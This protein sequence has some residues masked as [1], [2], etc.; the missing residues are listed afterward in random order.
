ME[1]F[2]GLARARD[3]P[4]R[5]KVESL[6]H[7]ARDLAGAARPVVGGRGQDQLVLGS[8][9][10]HVEE[11]PLL[12][13]V[14]VAAGQ[15]F[16]HE[17]G[18]QAQGVA[19]PLQRELLLGAA[20]QEDDR[21]LE[22]LGL[23][24]GEDV[25]R[26]VVAFGLGDGRIVAGLAQEVEVRDERGDAVVL[27]HVAVGLHGL[28]ELGDVLD[29][30]L[31]RGA[32]LGGQAPEGPGALEEAVED[33]A[34]AP[35]RH[36]LGGLVEIGQEPLRRLPGRA[37]DPEQVLA[38]GERAQDL[39]QRPRLPARVLIEPQEIDLGH[40]VDLR[41]AE[42]EERD[43]VVGAREHAEERDEEP[44]LL[45]RVEP[46]A[47]AEAMRDALD[48]QGAEEGLGVPVAAHQDGHVARARALLDPLLD[49]GG[50]A[51]GL[52][53]G[54]VEGQVTHG[55]VPR[56]LR[57][58]ALVD[59][60][61]HLQPI[62]VVVADE[63][64]RRVEDELGG[65]MVLGEDHLAGPGVE[66]AEGEQVGR[67]GASPTVDGLIVVTHHRDVGR[68]AGHELQHLELRVVRVLELV[69]Q[70]VAVAGAKTLQDRRAG[71]AAPRGRGGSDRR[72]RRAPPRPGASGGLRR[73]PRARRGS[74]L[75]LRRRG[76]AIGR[77]R[78]QQAGQPRF[79]PLAV[80]PWRDVLVLG[81]AH[82]GEERGQ[83]P[84]GIAERTE[85]GEGQGE[86]A[87]AQED[88][89][90]GLAQHAELG[91]HPHLE[92]GLAEHA[93]AEG[94][95][96]RDR[97]LGVAVGDELVDA[98]GHLHRGLLGEGEGQDLLGPRPLARDE[99]GDAAGEHRGLARARAG[100]DEE[101][102]LAV[103][104]GLAL[105]RGEAG[106][107]GRLGRGKGSERGRGHERPS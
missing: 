9:H 34:G 79:G 60:G 59:L 103:E 95:E 93:V 84:R 38:R 30:G 65:P 88:D 99:M 98:L 4:W 86:E 75:R 87:L 70:D 69:D 83:V 67:G 104:H 24:H 80:L 22:A 73:R 71:C 56:P 21:E 78:G 40:A 58:Q 68:V 106:E 102:P 74:G 63:A 14:P 107:N 49:E 29:L 51:I 92:R 77:G 54:G 105:G 16:L 3:R 44:D 19:P 48:V 94:V 62:R 23:V 32:A 96:G 6:D 7:E 82:Q 31:G 61:H 81:A 42:V 53:R 10:G 27:G 35:P 26:V 50:H 47:A 17:L 1:R 28:E 43:R 2:Q 18:R 64:R 13:D 8:R 101:G 89:G 90:L 85:A 37:A 12:V 39:E 91:V 45:A 46:A 55:R 66:A 5:G 97:G 33:L 41:G 15:L 25:H 20:H 72:S 52:G 57:P 11:P 76:E 36:L 100:D